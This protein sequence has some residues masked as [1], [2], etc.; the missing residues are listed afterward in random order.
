MWRRREE[1]RVMEEE[2]RWYW[3]ERRSYEEDLDYFD[4]C[5]SHSSGSDPPPT[6]PPPMGPPGM[7]RP[8]FMPPVLVIQ[9]INLLMA[10][11]MP[12]VNNPMFCDALIFFIFSIQMVDLPQ[13]IIFAF[14]ICQMWSFRYINNLTSHK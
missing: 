10:S 3:E 14:L 1:E 4:C 7:P 2:E 5:R 12:P 6:V 13:K 9:F 8:P 11:H